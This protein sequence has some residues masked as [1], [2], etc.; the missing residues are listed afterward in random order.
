MIN[1]LLEFLLSIDDIGADDS[2]EEHLAIRE[3]MAR[4]AIN[5]ADG[6]ASM[7]MDDV[8][9]LPYPELSQSRAARLH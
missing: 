8:D 1:D 9:G 7:S 4:R 6:W 3:E 5:R 2:I